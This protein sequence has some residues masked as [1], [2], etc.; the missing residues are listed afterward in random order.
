MCAKPR[1]APPPS[2]KPIRGGLGAGFGAGSTGAG[3]A[4]T[5]G[6]GPGAVRQPARVNAA[7]A[8]PAKSHRRRSIGGALLMQS[9][10][11]QNLIM[12]FR[13]I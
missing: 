13:N 10:N 7:A 1:A 8:A 9:E 5:T 4:A 2:A 6:A 12:F 11:K 3:G